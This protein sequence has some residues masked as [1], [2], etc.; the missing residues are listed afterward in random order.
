MFG[1]F[2]KKGGDAD[3][4]QAKALYDAVRQHLGDD[5]DIHVRIVASIAALLLCVA[6]ADQNYDED[7]ERVVRDVLGQIRQLVP[8]RSQNALLIHLVLIDQPP[9]QVVVQHRI[10]IKYGSDLHLDGTFLLPHV[11][12]NI[13]HVA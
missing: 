8:R 13:H 2:K 5:D 10:H 1:W 9:R 4:E 7:E 3:K 12:K 6:Y 11:L